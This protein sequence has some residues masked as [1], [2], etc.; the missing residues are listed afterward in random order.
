MRGRIADLASAIRSG[1]ASAST[2]VA[3][4]I[5]RAEQ[6]QPVINAFTGLWNEQP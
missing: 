2:I 6:S 3:A 1:E 5:D 4:A